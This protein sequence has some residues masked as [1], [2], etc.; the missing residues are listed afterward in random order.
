MN[1]V[2]LAPFGIRPKGTVIA[3]MLPLA[4][5]LQERG[6]RVTIIAPPYTNPEDAG[7]DELLRGVRL[8]NVRLGPGGRALSAPAIAWRMYRSALAEQPDL[9][10]LFK[11]K[12][13]GGLA[14]LFIAAFRRS[15]PLF[16]DT[17]DWEGK[18]GMNEQHGYSSLEKRFYAW[19]ERSLLALADGVTVASRALEDMVQRLGVS[20]QRFLYLPNCVEPA[21]VGDGDTARKRL[22]IAADTPVVLLYTRFFEFD[23]H[24]LYALCGEIMKRSP[25]CRLLVV[26]KGPNREEQA[27]LEES[28]RMGFADRLVMAGWVEVAQI[29]DLLAAGDVAIYPFRDDLVNRSKC[30]A[31]LTELMLTERAVVADRVGQLAEYI[32]DGENGILCSSGDWQGMADRVVSLLENSEIRR[33]LGVAARLRVLNDFAWSAAAEQLESFYIKHT[34]KDPV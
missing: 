2:F 15:L 25:A 1:I 28:R 19:Q 27:L 22:A 11:P 30:P 5:A 16:V 34:I 14:A 17:D 33:A 31:N 9:V 7:R 12:G 20:E 8:R 3:R 21:P 6:H 18:G 32:Q 24:L 4:A 26:G 23:Q 29:P 10:H 13:Y